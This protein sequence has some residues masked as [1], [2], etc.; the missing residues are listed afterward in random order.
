MGIVGALPRLAVD[1][2]GRTRLDRRQRQ[3]HRHVH[4]QRG[5]NKADV[6]PMRAWNPLSNYREAYHHELVH[7]RMK[8]RSRV[9]GD[10]LKYEH[11]YRGP[12][13]TPLTY[14]TCS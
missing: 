2:Y 13:P 1:G 12:G 5:A 8:L 4:D 9:L 3:P 7:P 10:N 11:F 14:Y 6:R